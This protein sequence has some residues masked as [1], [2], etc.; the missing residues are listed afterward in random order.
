MREILH[1]FFKENSGG[2]WNQLVGV[3]QVFWLNFGKIARKFWRNSREINKKI[4]HYFGRIM[5]ILLGKIEVIRNW[6][7]YY[8]EILESF[9]A[10]I[11]AKLEKYYEE[12]LKRSWINIGN[13]AHKFKKKH[14]DEISWYF[15]SNFW[16]NWKFK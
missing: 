6:C 4:F 8:E 15:H 1:K 16:K 2:F 3:L 13:T 5:E 9:S 11:L 12:I 14:F 7:W 10:I